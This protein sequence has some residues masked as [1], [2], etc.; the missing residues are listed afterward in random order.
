VIGPGKIALLAPVLFLLYPGI[1]I[2]ESRGGVEV[3]FGA[4][5][6]AFIVAIYKAIEADSRRSWIIA[7]GILG[8]AVLVRST[9]IVFPAFLLAYA[10]IAERRRITLSR[11]C[12]NVGLLTMAMTAVLSPWIIRNY[13][14][15]K[16]FIPTASVLG[17]SAQA[18][19]YI[20][21]NLT[22]SN[23][24]VDLDR[25]AGRERERLAEGAGY[26]VKGGYYQV[27]Y[28]TADE[29]T[30]SNYL[31]ARVVERYKANPWLCLKCAAYNVIN[32]WCAGKTWRST[33][34][35]AGLQ[36]PYLGFAL[37]GVVFRIRERRFWS[38]G[39]MLLLIVYTTLIC[40]PIL[41]QARYS[42]PLM[43]FVSI[44]AAIGFWE[45]WWWWKRRA[46]IS[47]GEQQFATDSPAVSVR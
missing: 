44:L 4:L 36:L 18:G 39:P 32:L 11:T 13:G 34:M 2:A 5:V 9:P 30:F 12:L 1:V 14:L 21:T 24:W 43:P 46:P 15:T 25:A 8:T 31:L 41:A 26:L 19:Q 38:L 23:R 29:I 20:C 7:G 47:G 10:W 22:F 45:T 3:L 17:V 33:A 6:T 16:R 35:N 37:A 40:A 27:F 28:N 42:V